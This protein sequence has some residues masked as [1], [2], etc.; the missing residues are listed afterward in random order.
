MS[1]PG[2]DSHTFEWDL[3][4][5]GEYDDATGENPT[6]I[7]SI[8]GDYTI[9][10]QVTD[11]DAGVGIDSATVSMA[12]QTPVVSGIPDT[13]FSEDASVSFDLDDY[14]EDDHPDSL[15]VWTLEIE[16]VKGSR[17]NCKAVLQESLFISIDSLTHIVTFSASPDWWG[18]PIRVVFTATDPEGLSGN[19]TMSVTVI[20]E[21]DGPDAP[22]VLAP[23]HGDTLTTASPTLTVWNAFDPDGNDILTYSFEVYLDSS[24]TDTVDTSYG[25]EQGDSVTG[26]TVSTELT[27]GTYWWVCWA[28]DGFE[29]G[30]RM[31][32][33]MFVVAGVGLEEQVIQVFPPAFKLSPCHPNPFSATTVI[34][35]Q[36]PSQARASLKVYDRSGKLVRILVNGYRHGYC[37]AVWD[38]R[39]ES[40]RVVP[41]GVYFYRLTAEHYTAT[42][43]AVMIR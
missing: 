26:W 40:G 2:S 29:D 42:E 12:N 1:D 5:D 36:L 25:V 30:E 38:G 15:L 41:N 9:Y 32:P 19:D 16:D 22:V 39:D 21:N 24:L 43:K 14:G 31:E 23:Q 28:N 7:W 13:S 20:S 33:S 8:S 4:G 37:R 3:D 35:Y 17:T 10:L 34:F 6:H 27:S 18:G 11:D